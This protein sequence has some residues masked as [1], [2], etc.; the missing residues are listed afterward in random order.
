M[1]VSLRPASLD[2]ATAIVHLLRELGYPG[3]EAFIERRLREL[4]S[5][6]D[7]LLQ[8]AEVGG[9]VVGV[10]ALQFVP[11]LALP[12]DF[13]RVTYLCVAGGARGL[14]IGARLEAWAQDE[15]RLRNCHRIELHCNAHRVD[16]HRFYDGLGY[17]ESPK[18][19]VKAT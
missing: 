17:V 11:Q 15:A 4:Q 6:T 16:A 5:R 12:R 8:V 9:V 7:T 2:D 14:G 10:I 13:C 19:L 18:Y 3:A 1:N